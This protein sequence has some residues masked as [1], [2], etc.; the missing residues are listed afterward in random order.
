MSR[1]D[2]SEAFV[3][4]YKSFIVLLGRD[5]GLYSTQGDLIRNNHDVKNCPHETAQ[6]TVLRLC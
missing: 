4:S 2:R 5:E 6:Q 1:I 3:A